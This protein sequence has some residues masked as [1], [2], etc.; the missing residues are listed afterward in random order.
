M[1]YSAGLTV[2]EIIDRCHEN[3]ATIHAHLRVREKY[4]PGLRA[5]HEAALEAR[6]PNRPTIKWRKRLK[7]ALAFQAAQDRAPRSD[8]D[9][10]EQSLHQWIADQR[11]A[12]MKGQLSVAKIILLEDL[13]SWHVDTHQRS[14]DDKWRST[15][16][17]LSDFVANTGELPR[18]KNHF[19][20][21]E[22][23]LGAWLHGQHQKRAEG[24]ILPWRLE[25]L[26]AALPG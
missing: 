24:T 7:E 6:D 9:A 14:L 13:T 23:V 4:S 19:A 12:Y 22:P 11:R 8:G 10:T 21:P 18:Y 1:M 25:A 26:D 15:L 3:V 17:A 5:K 20:E 16:S 2:R